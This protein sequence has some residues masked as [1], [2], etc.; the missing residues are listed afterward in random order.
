[1]FLSLVF[2]LFASGSGW[3]VLLGDGDTGWHIRTGD[4]ILEQGRVP[5]RDIFSFSRPDQPWFAWEWL[6]DL[7]FALLHR[8]L[9]LKGVVLLAG[10]T[11]AAAYTALFRYS[12]WRGANVP[13]ALLLTLMAASAG[14]VHFLAR[15]HVFTF[16]LLPVSLWLLERDEQSPGPAVWLLIPLTVLW[17]NLHGGFLALPVCLAVGA[18]A[19][20]ARAWRDGTAPLR[21]RAKRWGLL[22]AG[23]LLATLANPY[24]WRLH[25]HAAG[26]LSSGWIRGA[27]EEFQSPKFR[28]ESMA[29]FE[30]MLLG[31]LCLAA[32]LARRGDWYRA[33]LT[34]VWAHAALTSVRH[35]PLYALVAAPLL[36]REA[37]AWWERVS[38]GRPACTVLGALG[39]WVRDVSRLRGGISAW[40][41]TAPLLLLA[42]PGNWPVDF[43]EIKFPV[44]AVEAVERSGAQRLFTSDEWGDYL[45]YR[46][47]PRGRVFIDGRS[48][49]YGPGVGNDYIKLMQGHWE[50]RRLMEKYGF[51]AALVPVGWPLAELLK[52]E[53]GW[54]LRYDD[55]RAVW[56]ERVSGTGS[57]TPG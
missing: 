31:G 5:S 20:A 13:A 4:F 22:L 24:G 53:P 35:V 48:D 11:I 39:G 57:E 9:G 40:T 51:D 54:R 43:P 6:A 26:Y 44:R 56:L 16:L 8:L 41:M 36:A 45:I 38:A 17:V 21:D 7:I 15:P 19:A 3:T 2:W 34:L 10:V 30:V 28:S 33:G 42:G 27:V 25:G 18:G 52:R 37:S 12:V 55:G 50:W 46:R 49:F 23:C 32:V 29:Q 47:Y 1:M 14:A